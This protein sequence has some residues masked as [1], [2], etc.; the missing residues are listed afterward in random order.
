LVADLLVRVAVSVGASDEVELGTLN[1]LSAVGLANVE[2]SGTIAV[3]LVW[4]TGETG[5]AEDDTVVV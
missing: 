5:T 4:S 1:A 3:E 2:P